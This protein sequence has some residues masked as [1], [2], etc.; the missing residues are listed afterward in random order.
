[1]L[2]GTGEA[3]QRCGR[4]VAVDDEELTIGIDGDNGSVN[5]AVPA[6][7]STRCR[8]FDRHCHTRHADA[9]NKKAHEIMG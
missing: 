8:P 3:D 4:P 2:D 1:M 7:R 5:L 9:K 6:Y